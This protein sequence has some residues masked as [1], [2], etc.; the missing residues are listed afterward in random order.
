M[1][2]RVL[3]YPKIWWIFF[4]F[5]WVYHTLRWLPHRLLQ[6]AVECAGHLFM[7]VAWFLFPLT[8]AF[9]PANY[10]LFK[11]KM[12]QRVKE[13]SLTEEQKQEVIGFWQES[14]RK[15]KVKR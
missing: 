12:V 3:A 15:R 11:L 9:H 6:A 5:W 1:M 13:S 2:D 4:P 8:D 7:A 10:W 14:E